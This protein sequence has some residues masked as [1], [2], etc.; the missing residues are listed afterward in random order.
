MNRGKSELGYFYYFYISFIYY[1]SFKSI[2]RGPL[3]IL[4]CLVWENGK[5]SYD[6]VP[7]KWVPQFDDIRISVPG[8]VL[9]T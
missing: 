6:I 5:W 4:S 7:K 1:F 3:Y 8:F 9:V 2:P